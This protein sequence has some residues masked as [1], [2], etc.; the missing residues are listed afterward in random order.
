MSEHIENGSRGILYF[1]SNSNYGYG[2]CDIP[3]TLI[4]KPYGEGLL[5]I[6]KLDDGNIIAQNP[7]CSDFVGFEVFK[8]GEE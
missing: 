6:F 1:V 7:Y 4:E 3:A 5:W 2:R 8:G